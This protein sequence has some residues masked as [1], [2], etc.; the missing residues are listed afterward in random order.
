M[1]S[2]AAELFTRDEPW[3]NSNATLEGMQS[4]PEPVIVLLEILVRKER[5]K[6]LVPSGGGICRFDNLQSGYCRFFPAAE[7]YVFDQTLDARVGLE[8]SRGLR[9]RFFVVAHIPD[10]ALEMC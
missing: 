6:Q 5:L 4:A 10:L 8:Y 7:P 9:W 3:R 2:Q 1:D